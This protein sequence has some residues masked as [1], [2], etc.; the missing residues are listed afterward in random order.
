MAKRIYKS[1]EQMILEDEE[2]L[3]RVDA[4]EINPQE[5]R[6]LPKHL[7]AKRGCDICAYAAPVI[8]EKYVNRN[9]EK[10][11]KN[12]RVLTCRFD[13]CPL[14]ELDGVNTYSQWAREGEERLQKALAKALKLKLEKALPPEP[15]PDKKLTKRD[16]WLLEVRVSQGFRPDQI[17]S[18]FGLNKAQADREIKRAKRK[19]VCV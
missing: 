16:R 10:L 13:H 8:R 9:G 3:D 4:G 12:E 15:I 1:R 11:E 17:R 6:Y 18:E 2:M 14:H 19:R 5:E 7:R